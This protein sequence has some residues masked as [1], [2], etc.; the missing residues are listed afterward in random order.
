[1]RNS[2]VVQTMSAAIERISERYFKALRRMS[3]KSNDEFWFTRGG[4]NLDVPERN[5]T[6]RVAQESENLGFVPCLE[7]GPLIERGSV[8]VVS[9]DWRRGITILREA[10]LLYGGGVSARRL[11]RDVDRLNDV[12]VTT[13]QK[14]GLPERAVR[15]VIAT[16]WSFAP[17]KLKR[18]DVVARWCAV[19]SRPSSRRKNLAYDALL[20]RLDELHARFVSHE[21]GWFKEKRGRSR[22]HILAAIW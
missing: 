10:K 4:G 21:S 1:M 22:Q 3:H 9:V 19:E 12:D 7:V 5:L 20:E 6:W 16:T 18:A 17:E 8:D 15:M 2:A 11:H 13:L 14:L